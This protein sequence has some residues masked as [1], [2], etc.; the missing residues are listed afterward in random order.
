[1]FHYIINHDNPFIPLGYAAAFMVLGG[2]A[3]Y[4]GF[5]GLKFLLSSVGM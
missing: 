2:T 5:V 1:M 4:A 3:L